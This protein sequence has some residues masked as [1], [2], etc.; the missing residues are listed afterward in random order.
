[1]N[2]RKVKDGTGAAF[3][4]IRKNDFIKNVLRVLINGGYLYV[5]TFINSV[6]IARTIGPKGQGIVS[7][8]NTLGGMAVH[9]IGGGLDLAD[10]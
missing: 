5:L 10:R 7:Y 8:A 4:K 2:F 3:D 1:M 9:L 6:L